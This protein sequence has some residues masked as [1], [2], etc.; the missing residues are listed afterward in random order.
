MFAYERLAGQFS[1]PV[2][3]NHE[4]NHRLVADV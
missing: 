1:P 3:G 2:L 4:L